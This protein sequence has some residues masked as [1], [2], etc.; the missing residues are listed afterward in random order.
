M[1]TVLF[2]SSSY[3]ES[4]PI[5]LL[6]LG[7]V[8]LVLFHLYASC[9]FKPWLFFFFLPCVQGQMNLFPVPQYYVSPCHSLFG[10]LVAVNSVL[11]SSSG[12]I[13]SL[14]GVIWGVGEVSS[15][16]SFIA[17]LD[18]N[19]PVALLKCIFLFLFLFLVFCFILLCFVLS[20][21][22]IK[23]QI[24]SWP[25]NTIPPHRSFQHQV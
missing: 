9:S 19:Y 4:I 5:A 7:R 22:Q 1:Y 23:N 16:S 12:G 18:Q 20:K 24:S 17:I 21:A 10:C 14:I 8:V 25:L 13:V 6:L 15:M 2:S 11:H 3:L